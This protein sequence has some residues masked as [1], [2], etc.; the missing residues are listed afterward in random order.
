MELKASPFVLRE[1]GGTANWAP[2]KPKSCSTSCSNATN[3]GSGSVVP[4]GSEV[5]IHIYDSQGNLADAESW[6]KENVAGVRV[7]PE[8][9][10]T[11]YNPG[12]HRRRDGRPCSSTSRSIPGEG[13]SS[14]NHGKKSC[15]TSL[16]FSDAQFLMSRCAVV[17]F[18][19]IYGCQ[20]PATGVSDRWLEPGT[21]TGSR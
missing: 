9:T 20:A 1:A 14:A 11:F 10:G 15:I 7:V 6:Q 16:A 12:I 21:R 2:A 4:T 13:S 18:L 17:N 5:N 3:T 8:V 19:R